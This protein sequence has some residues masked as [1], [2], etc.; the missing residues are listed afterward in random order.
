MPNPHDT[1]LAAAARQIL[2]PLGFRRKG[3]SRIWMADHGSRLTIVEFQPSGWAKGSYLN[4]AAH[5]LWVEQ[6]HLSFDYGGRVETFVDY[7]SDTQFG[8]EAIRLAQ[9]AADEATLLDQ[10]FRSPDDVARVLVARERAL[11][12]AARG[13]WSAYHAGMA[14]EMAGRTAD[15]TALFQ[16]VQD[17]RVQPAVARVST[18]LAD[19]AGFRTEVEQLITAHRHTLGLH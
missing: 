19:P 15:A 17:P 8:P 3:R 6:D 13:S 9:A 2:G 11:P 18:L 7:V 14:A 12:K 16:S 1:L 4:V 10:T 5:W